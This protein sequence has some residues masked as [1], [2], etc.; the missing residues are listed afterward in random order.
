MAWLSRSAIVRQLSQHQSNHRH[1]D[2]TFMVF[3]QFLII[4]TQAPRVFEPSKRALHHPTPRLD[5]KSLP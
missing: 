1:L 3:R 4:A 2:E 5:H